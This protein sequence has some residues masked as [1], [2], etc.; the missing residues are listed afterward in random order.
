[1]SQC[2]K[3]G[4]SLHIC[5]K[6]AISVPKKAKMRNL[7]VQNNFLS[8]R[9]LERELALTDHSLNTKH[10][11]ATVPQIRWQQKITVFWSQEEQ[12]MI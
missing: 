12:V 9:R 8:S 7:T 3:S 5:I 6:T 10:F 2:T 11:L 4:L 1:M